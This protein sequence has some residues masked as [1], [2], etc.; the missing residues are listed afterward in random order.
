M[1]MTAEM[2]EWNKRMIAQDKLHKEAKK[3]A[4]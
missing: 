2:H 1:E 4:D 3:Q